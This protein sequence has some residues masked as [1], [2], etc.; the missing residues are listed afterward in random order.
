MNIKRFFLST[1]YK[2][3][4]KFP[5]DFRTKHSRKY[6]NTKQEIKNIYGKI[7]RQFGRPDFPKN[8]NN[9]TYLHLGCGKINHPQFINIDGMAFPHIH[10]IRRIDKLKPFQNGTVD[11]IY[12]SHCLEH[13][14]FE[15]VPDILIEWNRVLKIG[16]ILRLSV[17]D[18]DLLINIYEDNNQDIELILPPLL[19]GQDYKHNFHMVAFNQG[20]LTKLLQKAGFS[21]V[22]EWIPGTSPLMTF[23]DWSCRLVVHNGKAYPVSLNIEAIK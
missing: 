5:E 16:G 12:A 6:Q 20:Y 4:Y 3:K 2:L 9:K 10:F 17:P 22:Q 21:T 1:F 18:F 23:S 15:K 8:H 19:G 13:F 7:R 11:L 14:P